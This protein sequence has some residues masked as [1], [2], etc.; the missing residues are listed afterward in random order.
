MFQRTTHTAEDTRIIAEKLAK[1]LEPGDVLTLSGDL[2]A[3][4]TTF[5]QGLAKGLGVEDVVNS[6]T[7]TLIREYEGRL[8]LYHMDVYRLGEKAGSEDLGID[9]YLY[10]DG[11]SVIEWA[12]Y[13][14]PLLPEEILQVHIRKIGESDREIEITGKGSRFNGLLEE[15]KRSCRI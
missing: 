2:G 4:K 5:T 8:P 7:F 9:E 11:V 1:L 15:M 10:G 6:P 13:I 3:G 12:D 14:E